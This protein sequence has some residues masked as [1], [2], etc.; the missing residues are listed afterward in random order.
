MLVYNK[1]EISRQLLSGNAPAH[2]IS[3]TG[4]PRF[5]QLILSS[6]K[7]VTLRDA[8]IIFFP[9]DYISEENFWQLSDEQIEFSAC[10]NKQILFGLETTLRLAKRY[11]D[12]KFEIKSKITLATREI[13]SQ[14]TRNKEIPHN[15]ITIL[16]GGLARNSLS[17]CI[18][19]FGFNTT[20]LVD[21]LASGAR[22]AVLRHDIDPEK[23]ANFLIHFETARVIQQYS[24][25]EKWIEEIVS[26]SDSDGNYTL[27]LSSLD[28]ECLDNAVGNGDSKSSMR[29]YLELKA[30]D[31]EFSP[32]I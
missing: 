5:D 14:W 32:N 27:K 15:L 8:K 16:G 4:S 6:E 30:I 19:A 2:K 18:G 29:V 31:S 1:S 23:H 20:A 11:P 9:P 12:I 25:I 26:D 13:I 7:K 24:D 17:N 3:V 22:I 28:R 10:H 21:A